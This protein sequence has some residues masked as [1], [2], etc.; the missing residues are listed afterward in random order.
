MGDAQ[1]EMLNAWNN[2]QRIANQLDPYI[3]ETASLDPTFRQRYDLAIKLDA[4]QRVVDAF[5]ENQTKIDQL[6]K[7]VRDM[8][9]TDPDF[10]SMIHQFYNSMETT[11]GQLAISVPQLIELQGLS[12]DEQKDKYQEFQ[13]NNIKEDPTVVAEAQEISSE[14]DQVRQ[15]GFYDIDQ[16]FLETDPTAI[17]TWHPT[18]SQIL[19]AHSAGMNLNEYVDY[20]HQLAKGEAGDY[21]KLSKYNDAE[22]RASGLLDYSHFQDEL[23]LGG[24]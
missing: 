22:L 19:Q 17:T 3:V 24:I 20:M 16:A 1:L 6:P 8:A 9:N 14:E 11:A 5:Q 4:E 12:G 15:A 23:Q 7:N 2:E 18:D 10:D 13:F 21:R